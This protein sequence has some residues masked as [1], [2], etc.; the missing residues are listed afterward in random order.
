LVAAYYD[1]GDRLSVATQTTSNAIS[2][3]SETS[4]AGLATAIGNK[5]ARISSL[6]SAGYKVFD[7]MMTDSNG[8][9]KLLKT[10]AGGKAQSGGQTADVRKADGTATSECVSS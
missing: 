1:Q 9:R 6:R 2:A 3:A 5:A 8:G 10:P 4:K 7:L